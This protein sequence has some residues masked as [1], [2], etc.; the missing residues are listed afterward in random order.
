[1]LF[2]LL[3]LLI[4]QFFELLYL[5]SLNQKIKNK[6]LKVKLYIE[7]KPMPKTRLYKNRKT[8]KNVRAER[9]K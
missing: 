3:L 7:E 1:M 5:S 2:L 6:I 8:Y 9:I 4:L